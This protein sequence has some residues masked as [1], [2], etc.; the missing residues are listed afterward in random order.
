[1]MLPGSGTPFDID[2][3]CNEMRTKAR[4]S[5]TGIWYDIAEKEK[6]DAEAKAKAEAE[7]IMAKTTTT[8]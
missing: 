2:S 6:S 4:C 1:M 8:A 5:E 3:L 7:A